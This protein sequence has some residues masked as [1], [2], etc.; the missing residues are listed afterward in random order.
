MDDC[1]K[2][3]NEQINRLSGE[4]KK[5]LYQVLKIESQYKQS[6]HPDL[7]NTISSEIK[8]IVEGTIQ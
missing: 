7:I 5:I 2:Q 8:K 6:R 3:I 1:N 4:E